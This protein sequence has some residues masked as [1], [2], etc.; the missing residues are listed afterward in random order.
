[1]N[2]NNRH[3]F[4]TTRGAYMAVLDEIYYHYDYRSAPRGLAIREALDYSFSVDA[5]TSEPIVT[6]DPE[7][8]IKIAEYTAKELELYD[9]GSNRVEDF[10]K[11]SKFWTKLANPD[12]TV[13]SAYGHLL[14]KKRSHGNIAFHDTMVTPWEWARESLLADKDTRQ[15]VMRF[16]LPEHIWRGNKDQVC[17]L[18]ANWLIREDKLNLTVV[19]RSNDVV[20][21]LVYDMPWFC[22]L[23]NKMLDELKPRYSFLTKGR[24]THL[25]HSMHIYDRDEEMVLKMLGSK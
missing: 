13:N 21:G 10:A 24:Y 5:P 12:G 19:M 8:N 3:I 15:A 1:M 23:M 25:S 11:A 16:S 6:A 2:P 7:R 20:L 17:T 18:H 22:A 14:W 4:S 9:S